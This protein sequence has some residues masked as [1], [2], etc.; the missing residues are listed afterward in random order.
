[1]AAIRKVMLG[2]CAKSNMPG[3]C[4]NPPPGQQLFNNDCITLTPAQIALF[5]NLSLSLYEVYLL[6]CQS[7]P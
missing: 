7:R 6:L 1:M 5:P 2:M 3:I 4:G